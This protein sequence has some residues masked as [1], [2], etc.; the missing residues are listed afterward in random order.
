MPARPTTTR[1]V[2]AASTSAV[3]VVAERMTRAW[4]PATAADQLL[5]GQPELDVD[6]VAGLG[7][8]VQ[9]RSGPA[10]R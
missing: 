8:Q 7:H 4:A 9:A 5:G 1:S 3:T 2:P 6:L 10:S